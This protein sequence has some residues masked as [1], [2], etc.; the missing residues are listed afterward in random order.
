[1]KSEGDAVAE[2]DE[3]IAF[4]KATYPVPQVIE[5]IE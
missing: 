1:M 5:E 3:L 2:A 4:V